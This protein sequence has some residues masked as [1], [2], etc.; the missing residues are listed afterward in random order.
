MRNVNNFLSSGQIVE[1]HKSK[2]DLWTTQ[3]FMCTK[4]PTTIEFEKTGSFQSF[5]LV[6]VALQFGSLTP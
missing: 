4:L 5:V 1:K 2:K 3:Q 6:A